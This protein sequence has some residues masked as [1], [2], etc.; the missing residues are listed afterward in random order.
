MNVLKSE[1]LWEPKADSN[2]PSGSWKLLKVRLF[3]GMKRG[4]HRVQQRWVQCVSPKIFLR[5]KSSYLL[6]VTEFFGRKQQETS[7]NDLIRCVC[8]LVC[9][10]EYGRLCVSK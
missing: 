5:T 3:S 10:R 9:V 2:H 1:H 7:L 4:C 6:T 8:A